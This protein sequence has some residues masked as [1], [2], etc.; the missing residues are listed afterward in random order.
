[1][2]MRV[3]ARLIRSYL[4]ARTRSLTRTARQCMRVLARLVRSYSFARTRP[5]TRTARQKFVRGRSVLA[6]RMREHAGS[7]SFGSVVLI[8]TNPFARERL[9]RSFY[10]DEVCWR[11]ACVSMRVLARLIRSYSFARTRPLTRTA[12]QKF[13]RGRSVLASRMREHAGSGTFGSVVLIR[14]NPFAN[15]NGSPEVCTRTKC[16]GEPHA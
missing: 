12:R 1:M 2:S 10:A 13:V 5:L 9:A 16:V 8:R 7:G 4:F 3:L 11:A 14:T 6:S 15:A